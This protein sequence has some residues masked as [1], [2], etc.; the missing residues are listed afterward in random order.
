MIRGAYHITVD[1]V[2]LFIIPDVGD[3]SN[4]LVAELLRQ[5]IGPER[6]KIDVEY[7]S[8]QG[9]EIGRT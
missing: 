3:T 7:Q 8:Y 6:A 4:A 1:R 9:L 2:V 5:F